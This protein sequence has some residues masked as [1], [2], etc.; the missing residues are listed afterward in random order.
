MKVQHFYDTKTNTLTY[1]VFDS[2][3]LDAIIIDPVLDYDPASGKIEDFCLQKLIDFI[4]KHQLRP[5][6]CLETHAHAD[7]L[8][9]SQFLKKKYPEL[10]I[11][12]SEKITHV[13]KTFSK[14]LE[15]EGLF[16]VD[17][18]QF[19]K[20]IKEDETFNAGTIIIKAVATPGHTPACLS[21]LI[22]H[23]IFTG[24][25]LFVD[26]SGTGRCD[27][28]EGSAKK[29][30]HSIQE[31]LY[32]LPDNTIVFVGHDYQPLNRDLKFETTIGSAKLHNSHLLQSTSE[33]SYIN[34]REKRDLTLGAP[35]LLFQ[36][37]QVNINAG[38]LPKFLKMPLFIKTK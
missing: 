36:S 7:H 20:L 27:F 15:I 21:F 33:E 37:I 23:Y 1:I 14:L 16:P 25:A 32:K 10:Q 12:I 17:G 31:N 11:A 8:S 9:S 13:Q 29:L 34:F 5:L 18:S 4:T 24:D 35:R 38:I 26:D 6:F 22:N 19:D 3:S 28:P 2:Q 30:Y